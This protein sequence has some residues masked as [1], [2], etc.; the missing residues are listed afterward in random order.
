VFCEIYIFA[1]IALHSG[2]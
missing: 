1:V 2:V